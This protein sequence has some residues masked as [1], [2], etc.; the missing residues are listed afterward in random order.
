ML[1]DISKRAKVFVQDCGGRVTTKA[2]NAYI[3]DRRW[4]YVEYH[5]E[6]E[7]DKRLC[8]LSPLIQE[9]VKRS[10]AF[11]YQAE[12][13]T[14]IAVGSW[15]KPDRKLSLIVH[16]IG[17]ILLGH[18]LY[19]L[20][21]RMEKDADRFAAL[22]LGVY[23]QRA[24]KVSITVL[25]AAALLAAGVALGSSLSKQPPASL[26]DAGAS[27]SVLPDM[28]ASSDEV[29]ITASG[30]KYHLPDCQYV[31]DRANVT[32]VTVS[33]ALRLGKEPCKV[34]QPPEVAE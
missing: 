10:D 4:T 22:V 23:R 20:T 14:L 6:A 8:S 3:K 32:A 25:V 33:E 7:L 34:C 26:A 28:I 30:D 29:L 15:V 1:G 2:V 13:V 5:R 9:M 12:D 11:A 18:D 21:D 24:K 27:S 31:K 19:N 17:H 16:E